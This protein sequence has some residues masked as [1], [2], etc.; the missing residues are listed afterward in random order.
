MSSD[1]IGY[2]TIE[3]KKNIYIYIYI[4]LSLSLSED[5]DAEIYVTTLI[6]SVLVMFK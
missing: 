4:S 2:D 5:W 1:L 6:E 3:K